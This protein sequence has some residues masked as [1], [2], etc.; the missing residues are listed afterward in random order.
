MPGQDKQLRVNGQRHT[1]AVA[2]DTPL[3]WV[4]REQ[5]GLTGTHFGCGTGECGSCTV[6][7]D[8]KAQRACV[9]PVAAVLDREITTIEGL[10]Q[11]DRL[12]PV[13]QAWLDERVSQ[14][15]YCQSGQIMTLA[16][17]L[18]AAP[19]SG[20]DAAQAQMSTVLCRCGTHVRI[21]RA[22]R[23][24]LEKPDDKT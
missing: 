9:V 19:N 2:D 8:G 7:V 22:M 20:M 18:A 24:L 13:Q 11:G 16:A 17:L 23:R 1:V 3:L 21:R 4:L 6:H 10:A 15:G 12:H 14:C 5:L